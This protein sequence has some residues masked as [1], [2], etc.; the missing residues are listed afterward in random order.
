MIKMK[1]NTYKVFLFAFLFYISIPMYAQKANHS[2]DFS[3]PLI[4]FTDPQKIHEEENDKTVFKHIEKL[5][6]AVPEGASIHLSVFK[7]SSKRIKEALLEAQKRGV[8]VHIIVDYGETS[9]EDNKDL[10]EYFNRKLTRFYQFDNNISGKAIIH[11]KFIIC[12]MVNGKNGPV[13]NVVLQTSSNFA[14]VSDE[15]L[16]DLIIFEDAAIYEGYLTYWK[17]MEKLGK[18]NKLNEFNYFTVHNPAKTIYAGFFPKRKNGKKYGKDHVINMLDLIENPSEADIKIAVSKWDEKRD[19]VIDKLNELSDQGAKIDIITSKENDDETKELIKGISE[20][21]E[22]LGKKTAKM[23]TRYFLIK[24]REKGEMKY[25]VLTGS[26][27]LTKRS[28][29]KNFEVMLVI[30]SEEAYQKYLENFEAI[31][32]L[33]L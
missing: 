3:L 21:I 18:A 10:Y 26:Q 11:N 5:I 28:L 24:F 19:D 4:T 30:N 33:K 22:L 12:S 6:N 9:H 29:R 1:F 25:Y 17:I 13:S 20:N 23:H 27:N 16:Q 31:K 15:R 8:K 7:L 2:L 14:K 32:N